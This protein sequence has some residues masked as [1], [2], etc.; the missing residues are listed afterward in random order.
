MDRKSHTALLNGK[1]DHCLRSPHKCKICGGPIKRMREHIIRQMDRKSHTALLNV[2]KRGGRNG[3]S[4]Q[5][6]Q[7]DGKIIMLKKIELAK[8]FRHFSHFG[9]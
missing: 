7:I 5:K 4:D 8:I 6:I 9:H 3:Q 2:E 1:C